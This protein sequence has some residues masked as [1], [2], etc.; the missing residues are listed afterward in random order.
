MQVTR[1]TLSEWF[2]PLAFWALVVLTAAL[3][4]TPVQHLPQ[5]VFDLWDK[6]QHALG[7]AALAYSGLSAYPRRPL[8]LALGLLAYGVLI[9]WV[10]SATGW[11]HGDVADWLAD[12][13]GVAVGAA[14]W[15]ATRRW[16][17]S[18]EAADRPRTP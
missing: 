15:A 1:R 4:W 6:A 13:L 5:Q 2:W 16:I 9:E 12:A 10:Q 8:R 18:V 17:S 14:V 7:F 3:S 11:R